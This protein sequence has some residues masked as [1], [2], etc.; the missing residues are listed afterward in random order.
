MSLSVCSECQTIEGKWRE[1]T[2]EE[3]KAEGIDPAD[4]CPT[5]EI[6]LDGMVCEDCGAIG[7]HRGIPEHDD[8]DME[9]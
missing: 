6:P 5:D 7:S 3:M 8:Y 9:R 4:I 2:V 1:P